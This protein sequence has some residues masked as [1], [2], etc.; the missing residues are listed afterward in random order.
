MVE[1][2]LDPMNT[3]GVMQPWKAHG[4]YELLDQF[5]NCHDKLVSIWCSAVSIVS[6]A[7]GRRQATQADSLFTMVRY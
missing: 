5:D 7:N 6:I 3:Q 4:L 2:A 1:Q